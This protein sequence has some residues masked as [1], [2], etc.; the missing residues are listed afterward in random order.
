M[1]NLQKTL[2][3]FTVLLLFGRSVNAQNKSIKVRKFDLVYEYNSDSIHLSKKELQKI[4]L[5]YSNFFKVI[6]AK[7][8]N[9]F[10][11]TLSQKTK[12]SIPQ[13][14]LE[15]KYKKFIGYSV[16][17]KNKIEIFKGI[18]EGNPP[19]FETADLAIIMKLSD[20]TKIAKRVGFDPVKFHKIQ[21]NE[22]L[23]GLFLVKENGKYKVTIPW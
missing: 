5:A 14:K 4:C 10:N 22:N 13:F 17:L 19:S 16:S 15:R 9:G 23:V 3:L 7:D 21:N 1:L 6:E 8:Y 20:G 12:N 2:L 11:N 18:T